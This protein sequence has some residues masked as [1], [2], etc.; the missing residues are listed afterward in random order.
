VVLLSNHDYCLWLKST[1]KPTTV[2]KTN[3]GAGE[4]NMSNDPRVTHWSDFLSGQKDF[5]ATGMDDHGGFHDFEST[6]RQDA[7]DGLKAEVDEANDDD[8]D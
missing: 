1:V 4:C 5:R 6:N 7:I 8:D 3:D 2:E